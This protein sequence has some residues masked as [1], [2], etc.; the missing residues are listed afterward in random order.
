[1]TMSNK[2]RPYVPT[3]PGDVLKDELQARG[4]SQ[5][6]FA[7]IISVSYTM[8]NE[9]INC[10]RPVSAE[11]ALVLEA[12]LGIN[13]SLW[14]NMQSRYNLEMARRNKNN[15]GKLETIRKRCAS[16]PL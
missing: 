12:A 4:I 15:T 16:A 5:K 11:M 2:L 6:R 13:A 14:N 1:M 9:I 7:E 10:K 8:L 3:H